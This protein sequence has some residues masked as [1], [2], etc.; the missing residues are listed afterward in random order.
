MASH[1]WLAVWMGVLALASMTAGPHP[2]LVLPVLVVLAVAAASAAAYVAGTGLRH[3]GE[4]LAVSVGPTEPRVRV[5]QGD[6]DAA[7]RVRPRAP[8]QARHRTGQRPTWDQRP[9]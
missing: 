6:P 4:P 9:T 3:D 5:R 8:G 2:V 7:G 1:R